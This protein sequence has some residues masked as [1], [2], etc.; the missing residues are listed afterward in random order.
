MS[1]VVQPGQKEFVAS[2]ILLTEIQPQKVLMVHHAKY[3]LWIQPGGHIEFD[4]NPLEAAVREAEE[5]TGIDIS[6]FLR[7]GEK[8]D[9]YAFP[10]PLPTL[11]VEESIS[12]HENMPDHFHLDMI[13][14]VSL[15]EE[16]EPRLEHGK[17]KDIGWFTRE[18][19]RELKT[20]KNTQ[21]MLDQVMKQKT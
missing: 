11:L 10:L 13:Y 4:E 3:D 16:I 5:E 18:E 21:W 19:A 12:A 8:V 9:T 7:P 14:V 6:S 20:F 1:R 17:A 15:P 2:I